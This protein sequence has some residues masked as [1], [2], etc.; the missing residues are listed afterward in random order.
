[1]DQCVVSTPIGWAILSGD[2]NGLSRVELVDI[3]PEAETTIPETLLEAATQLNAYFHKELKAFDLELNPVGS[4]FERQV[5]TALQT[6]PYGRTMSYLELSKMLGN[7]N[8]IRAVARANGKN[9]LWIVIP[10]HRIIGSDGSLTGYA[11]GLH[12][13]H[14]LLNHEGAI[15]QQSLF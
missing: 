10:C 5:W 3:E 8:T 14:W 2:E 4:P 13:K 11:G 12:R 9:P 15:K 7:P 1:M 6:V